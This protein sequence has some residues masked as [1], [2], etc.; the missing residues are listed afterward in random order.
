MLNADPPDLASSGV[1]AATSAAAAD[2]KLDADE[3]AASV[4]LN[5]RRDA[6]RELPDFVF[7]TQQA[8]VNNDVRMAKLTDPQA[9]ESLVTVLHGQEWHNRSDITIA[10]FLQSGDV[11]FNDN[12][13]ELLDALHAQDKTK[14]KT[15]I[16]VFRQR[17]GAGRADSKKQIENF[18]RITSGKLADKTHI[19]DVV[20]MYMP[21]YNTKKV[22]VVGDKSASPIQSYMNNM[23]GGKIQS[24]ASMAGAAAPSPVASRTR[25]AMDASILT[26]PGVSAAM[27]DSHVRDLLHLTNDDD[28]KQNA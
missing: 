13:T 1:S 5:L 14:A 17:F 21:R 15:E 12:P 2:V 28:N 26:S 24:L 11:L 27:D 22:H 16:A 25:S 6:I 3:K 23:V 10:A 7:E 4:G 18:N 8:D 9:F 19:G 20:F